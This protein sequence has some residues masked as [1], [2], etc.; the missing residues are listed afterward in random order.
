MYAGMKVLTSPSSYD[1]YVNTLGG[2][3]TSRT[4]LYIPLKHIHEEVD[5]LFMAH[6]LT[7]P[8]YKEI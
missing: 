7:I 2:W 3:N 4:I 5:F 8:P 1:I 6:D